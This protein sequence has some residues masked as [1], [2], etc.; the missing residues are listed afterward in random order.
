MVY[1]CRKSVQIERGQRYFLFIYHVILSKILVI[2][3]NS[4]DSMNCY[5]E[6]HSQI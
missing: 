1:L 3:R 2:H 5:D 4:S 6:S